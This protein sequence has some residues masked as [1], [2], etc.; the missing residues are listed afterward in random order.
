MTGDASAYGIGAVISLIMSDGAERPSAFASRTLSSSERNYAQVKKEAL[1]PVFGV[2]RFRNYLYG[3]NFT[4]VMDH[5]P[6]TTILGPKKCVPPL[7]AARLQ[8]W[9]II[10]SAYTYQIKLRP[11]QPHANADGLSRLPLAD[12]MTE[13][14]SSEP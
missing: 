2:E 14:R 11:T 6:L 10:L 5:K 1:S 3:H 7:A 13:G 12:N 8:K 9:A 4:L